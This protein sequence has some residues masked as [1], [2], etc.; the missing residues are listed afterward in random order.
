[1]TKT[2]KTLIK[3]IKITKTGKIMRKQ[4][5][6][7]HLKRKMDVSRKHRKNSIAEQTNPGHIKQFKQLLGKKGR[8]IK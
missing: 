8:S 5:R 6:T 3:R 4:T 1:M 7:G 2:K